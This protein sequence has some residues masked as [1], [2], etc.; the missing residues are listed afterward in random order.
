[1]VAGICRGGSGV[2]PRASASRAIRQ[3]NRVDFDTHLNLGLSSINGLTLLQTL[4][5]NHSVN[6]EKLHDYEA[7]YRSQLN[8]KLSLDLATFLSY[9]REL[10][11]YEPGTPILVTNPGGP[12]YLV[13]PVTF[14]NLARA[15]NYGA[16]GF[17]NW[18]PIRRW[19]LSP[20]Y[21][22]LRMS[23]Q[24][25]PGSRDSSIRSVPGNSPRHHFQARSVL[26]LRSNIEWNTTIRYVSLV[27]TLNTPAYVGADTTLRWRPRDDLE[28]SVTG[29]NL[30]R[31]RHQ[32]FAD[33]AR[34]LLP[35][36]VQRSVFVKMA[37][38]F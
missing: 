22:F 2:K 29:Q 26:N 16:E 19:T 15:R 4:S 3:P 34:I 31:P 7:G 23:T 18:T 30:L 36:A 17:F 25:E 21:S 20:G 10:E 24:I 27:A 38:S 33:V 5:G 13:L 1:V 28:V 11:T 35:T 8:P 6:A 37:W 9:Y 12:P 14:G 32:E